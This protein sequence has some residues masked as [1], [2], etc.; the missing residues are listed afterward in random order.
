SARR[1]WRGW[2]ASTPT[3]APPPADCD[4]RP[5]PP[6]AARL[7]DETQIPAATVVIAG[8]PADVDALAGTSF[9]AT[10]PPPVRHATL[11]IGLRSLPNSR[12]LVAF[13]VDKPLY[14][15]VHSAVAQ[16]AP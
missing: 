9:A 4:R 12:R 10:L 2:V 15:S 6:P 7:G 16:L 8:A 1:S 11:D 5:L 3:P 13:G 14:F